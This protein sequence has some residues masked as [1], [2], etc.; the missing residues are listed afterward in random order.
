MDKLVEFLANWTK[1]YLKSK[2]TVTKSLVSVEEKGTELVARFKDRE[3]RIVIAPFMNSFAEVLGE[4]T[5]NPEMHLAVVTFNSEKSFKAL[6]ENW[7]E[8]VKHRN[9]NIY[10]VNPFSQL[11]KRWIIFPFTHAKICDEDS[12]ELG[13]K[14]MFEMVDRISEEE[15]KGKI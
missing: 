6:L 7:K 10:F 11:D 2:N 13:L 3:Q 14:S 4:L 15:A 1:E 8:L 9:F 5:K 12:L